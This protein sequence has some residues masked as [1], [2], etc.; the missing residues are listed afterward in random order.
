M[1]GT[2]PAEPALGA[3]RAALGPPVL[4]AEVAVDRPGLDLLTYSVPDDL[5]G[6]LAVGDCVAAPLGQQDLRGFVVSLER[7]PLPTTF[8]VRDLAGRQFGVRVPPALLGLARWG[9][10]YYRCTLGQ[11]LGGVVPSAVKTARMTETVEL[12]APVQGFAGALSKRQREL[13]EKLPV[14]PIELAA[15]I[16]LAGT[17]AATLRKLAGL[18]ALTITS[19]DHELRRDIVETEL[20][21]GDERH[22]LTDE[23]AAAVAAVAAG[24]DSPA[25]QPTLLHGITGSGKTLVYCELAERCIAS[26]RQVLVLLPEIGLTPQLA[27]RF[28]RRIPRTVVWH[29]AFAAGERAEGWRRV[30]AGEADLVLGTRSALFAPLARPGLIIVDEEHDPSYKSELTPRYHARD[31]ALVYAKQL[32]IPV[33]LGSATPSLESI[34][35]ARAKRYQVVRLTR[36]PAGGALPVPELVDMRRECQEQKQLAVLSRRLVEELATVRARG[37]QAIVLL[38]RRGWSPILSCPA[39]GFTV[40]CVACAIPLTFHRGP[41]LLR[42]HYCGHHQAPPTRCPSCDHDGMD[43]KGVGTEQLASLINAALPDLRMIR[44]DADTVGTKH[45]HARLLAAFAA[46]AAD[47]LVG[48]QMVAKG[49]DFPRVTLVGVVGADRSLA[50]PE[51]RAAERTWQLIAQVSGRAGRADKPGR[52]IVQAY[53]VQAAAL[54]AALGFASVKDF[55]DNELDLRRAYGY[56]PGSGLARILWSGPA[57]AK[58][59]LAAIDGG[60]RLAAVADDCRVLEPC[61]AGMPL[62]KGMHRWHVLIKGP[63]RGA[64]QRLF[65]RLAESSN[66]TGPSGL[67]ESNAVRVTIDIDPLHTS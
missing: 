16:I 65:D 2:E 66:A 17:T 23:Q 28:R 26:G 44:L 4:L 45:G 67:P 57:P 47:C 36:R 48:T 59:Q 5:A 38:N 27:A 6:V 35:N 13:L 24:F 1:S 14:E 3:P 41:G 64:V 61:P 12:V 11:F 53:D 7:R 58:V 33:V 32:A 46:G 20:S 37:E 34:A 51:F 18:G 30:A 10:T 22:P 19:E 63:S 55:L 29:S 9:A 50:I 43:A 42:C 62:L 60:R 8:T 39:C 21:A 25:P 49:L 56:P 40:E 15:A 52:V 31:L 54:Q